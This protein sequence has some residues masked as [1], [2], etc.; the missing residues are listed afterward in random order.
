MMA[1]RWPA[2]GKAHEE[3]ALLSEARQP[4]GVLDEFGVELGVPM[5]NVGASGARSPAAIN[6]RNGF[7]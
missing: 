3:P 5:P 7:L 4:V 6:L 1:D 2:S